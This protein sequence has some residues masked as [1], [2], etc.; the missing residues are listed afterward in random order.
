MLVR[1]R[2]E[3]MNPPRTTAAHA[4]GSPEPHPPSN[5]TPRSAAEHDHRPD[6]TPLS[7]SDPLLRAL[8]DRAG[9]PAGEHLRTR[10]R[11]FWTI[12]TVLTAA[13][14]IAVLLS[15]L[16]SQ[17]CRANGW[18]GVS[19]YHWGC[20]SD[21]AALWGTRDLALNP[22]APFSPEHSSFEYPALTM[23]LV[24]LTALVTHGAHELLGGTGVA[25][26]GERTGL[27]FWDLTFLAA[28][29]A[30]LVLVLATMR[31]AGHRPWDAAVVAL[32]PALILG[33]G[34]NWDIWPAAALALAVLAYL[35]G[36]WWLAGALIGVGVSFKLYPLLM[37]GAVFTLAVRSWWKGDERWGSRGGGLASAQDGVPGDDRGEGPG[38]TRNKQP[39]VEGE[40]S[41]VGWPVFLKIAGGSLIAWLVINVPVMLVNF[42]A[43]SR[44]FD[45]SSERGAGYSSV[46]HLSAVLAE[47]GPTP[48]TVSLWSVLLFAA[49]CAGVLV[50]GVTAPQRPRMVQLLFLIVV[51]FVLVNKVYSPQF[52]IWL[53]PLMVLAAPRLRD[54][55][56][57]HAFQLAHFW[58]VWMYLAGI[59]GDAAPEHTF[60]PLLYVAAVLGHM[61]ATAYVAAQVIA[62]IY[63]P[64][65]DVVRAPA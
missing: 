3:V 30:W 54:I 26:W 61:L 36:H 16:T 59:V 9:G 47:P 43:W 51:A 33:V 46:W 19:M 8:S 2:L 52:M 28:A 64:E 37:L 25:Y 10:R 7:A 40:V 53:V 20:Y 29:G 32:S 22:W 17:F 45:F 57:W 4:P 62:D 21:V 65:R 31:A 41:G 24:S 5:A 18:D 14:V 39:D 27:L 55:V 34:I 49:A 35:R 56:M 12:P 60:D 15:V 6:V 58:A 13:T 50:I 23:L 42:E 63:R 1:P 38:G 44:F 48:E 11:G